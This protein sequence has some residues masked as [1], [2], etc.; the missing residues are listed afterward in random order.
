MHAS[1]DLI[2]FARYIYINAIKTY[3][4]G[5]YDTNVR[6]IL[7]EFQLG[8]SKIPNIQSF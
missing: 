7:S 6:E 2:K 4:D 8:I 3:S 5:N 1:I